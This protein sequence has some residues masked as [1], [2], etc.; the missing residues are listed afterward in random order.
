[1]NRWISGITAT[2]VL[3][4]AIPAP[5]SASADRLEVTAF[6]AP[7]E[8]DLDETFIVSITVRNT[9]SMW[10]SEMV[11]IHVDGIRVTSGGIG[12]APGYNVTQDH[13]IAIS[14]WGEHIIEA[15]MRGGDY[16]GPLT[17]HVRPPPP[18]VVSIDNAT[19]NRLFPTDSAI[20]VNQSNNLTRLSV[21]ID[22]D[23][24]VVQVAN[25]KMGE[26]PATLKRAY[27]DHRAGWAILEIEPQIPLDRF[28]LA[29]FELRATDLMPAQSPLTV[30]IL[31]AYDTQGRSI[32]SA[33]I[34]GKFDA[35]ILPQ[36]QDVVKWA[37]K[38]AH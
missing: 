7:N 5:A 9:R 13:F 32:P 22:Y 20:F 16:G 29:T 3:L 31:E 17:I 18:V 4:A 33:S 34:D 30:T 10:L 23:P 38:N 21:R 8:V 25:V 11:D 35:T 27:V 12:L 37:E 15:H 1:M 36:T 24:N 6:Q 26:A 2:L 28:T 14:S 19:G